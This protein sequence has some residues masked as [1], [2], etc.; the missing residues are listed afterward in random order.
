MSLKV[1]SSWQIQGIIFRSLTININIFGNIKFQLQ[2][3]KRPN[4]AS[5]HK[6]A[7]SKAMNDVGRK[8][9][10]FLT[11]FVISSLGFPE[12]IFSSHFI[13]AF[14]TFSL[15]FYFFSFS[16]LFSTSLFLI[17]EMWGCYQLS[18]FH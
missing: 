5:V 10:H 14:V 18:A 6:F 2:N 7:L 3:L 13:A 8:K 9:Q 16:F 17:Q 15:L 11:N 12:I 4:C 1:N